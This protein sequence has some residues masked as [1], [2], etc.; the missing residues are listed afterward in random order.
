MAEQRRPNAIES[1]KLYRSLPELTHRQIIFPNNTQPASQSADI[2]QEIARA[3]RIKNDNA[4]QDIQLKRNTWYRLFRFLITETTVVFVL[5][6]F[7]A[8]HWPW[9]FHLEEWS[10]K[11]VVAVTIGQI[12]AMLYVAVRYLFPNSGRRQR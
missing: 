10:F 6:F 11:L 12:T 5:A 8:I 3:E 7:Q 1:T 2:N 4:E 9:Q